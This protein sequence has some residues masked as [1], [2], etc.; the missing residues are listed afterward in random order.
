MTKYDLNRALVALLNRFP[1]LDGVRGRT[2]Q[3]TQEM[4][5]RFEAQMA[6]E[7]R[8]SQIR[9]LKRAQERRARN[10]NK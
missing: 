1:S 5:A 6:R 8:A 3:E 2:Q 10:D 7:E 4:S 9:E